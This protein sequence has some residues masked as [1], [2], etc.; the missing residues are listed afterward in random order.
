MSRAGCLALSS[1][2]RSGL[3]ACGGGDD[4]GQSAATAAPPPTLPAAAVP[5][6]ESK[7][8]T[9]TAAAVA[10]ETA[11]PRLA[12]QLADWGYESGASRYFQGQSKRL[13][14]VDSRA[15]R[16]RSPTGAAALMRTIR[17]QPGAFFPGA[18]ESR[19]VRGRPAA[20]GSRSRA[21]RAPAISRSPPCSPPW[22]TARRSARCEINGARA[23]RRVLR[24]LAA[25][26]L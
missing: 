13:Q 23:T 1:A 9:L 15:Y 14:V 22:R 2:S 16:F 17:E 24:A 20:A 6:L 25:R 18:G 4:E 19:R 7:A 5:Y 26:A 10:K 11:L 3:G 12:S 21:C 8:R